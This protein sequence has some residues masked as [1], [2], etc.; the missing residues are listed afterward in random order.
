MKS[1]A[2]IS[3]SNSYAGRSEWLVLF[4]V[5]APVHH[6]ARLRHIAA[7][8]KVL[9]W[10]LGYFGRAKVGGFV[11]CTLNDDHPQHLLDRAP[12]DASRWRRHGIALREDADPDGHIVLIG[13]GSKQRIY[14]GPIE[15][16]RRTYNDLVN[17]FPGRRIVYRPKKK[18][19]PV[20]LPCER[21][22]SSPI[23]DLLKG[24]ALVVCRHSNVAVD[25]A[26]AGVPFEA[27]DGAAMWLK[28]RE[29]T[30]ANRLAFLQRLSWFQW[31]PNEASKALDFIR[32]IA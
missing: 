10:D 15:W 6:A 29:F 24:A 23:A 14:V 27:Q 31:H 2:D 5:G 16:E 32:S 1:G 8:G 20:T 28:A 26:I 3:L 13:L 11:R 21:N 4:G 17:R 19:D 22:G 12:D 30:P 9:I 18:D 7:G 25:A